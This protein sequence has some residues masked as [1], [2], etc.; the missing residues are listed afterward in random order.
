MRIVFISDTHGLHN[1]MLHLIP[2]GDVLIHVGDCTNVGTQKNFLDF[3]HWY[4]NL[5]GFDTKVFIAGNHD[6]CFE[7]KPAWLRQYLNDENMSQSDCV[8]LEDD[9]FTIDD[10]EFSKPIKFYGSPW[11]P[12]FCSWAFNVPRDQLHLHWEKIPRDVDVLI[13]HGPPQEILDMNLEGEQ[14]GCS[15]L[16]FHVDEIKPR[17]HAFGHIHEDYGIKETEHTTFVN[18]STATR[19]YVM[20]NKPIIIDLTEVDGKLITKIVD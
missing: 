8:Y 15:S 3:M 19:R 13:T 11:Q 6:W 17:I 1:T 20:S 2:E 9:S 4:Q 12:E 18:A 16:R 5:K 10:P 14:C 7:T